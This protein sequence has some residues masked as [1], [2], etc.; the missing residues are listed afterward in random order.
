MRKLGYDDVYKVFF[1]ILKYVAGPLIIVLLFYKIG[2]A[3]IVDIAKTVRPFYFILAYVLFVF[4]LLTAALNLHI[5]LRPLKVIAWERFLTYY[6]ASRI[7]TLILPGRLGEFSITYFLEKE[8]INLGRGIAAVITDKLTT[9]FCSVVIGLLG[10]YFLFGKD[11]VLAIVIYI[12]LLFSFFALLLS[13]KIR[14][15]IRKFIL[16]K[17]AHHFQGFSITLFSYVKE[18]KWL[19]LLNTFITLFR[20]V[21]IAFSAKIIFLSIGEHVPLTTLILV[22]GLETLST[23][24]PLTI[25]GLGIKQA[26]GIYVF[27]KIGISPE[28]SGTRYLIGLF[29]QYSFGLFTTIFLRKLEKKEEKEEQKQ[30]ET[31]H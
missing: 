26:V 20:I 2:L 14:Y 6:F 17:Y 19:T 29:I 27:S 7:T 18:H 5:I 16:R 15:F 11:H 21:L 24:I 1:K 22:E 23:L 13:K 31:P 25:N 28:I 12:G 30:H 4:S 9:T 3:N 8:S 10:S